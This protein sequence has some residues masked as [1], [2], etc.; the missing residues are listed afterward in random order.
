MDIIRLKK[1]NKNK[2]EII[3]KEASFVLFDD[4]ILKY[5]L[6]VNKDISLKQLNEIKKYDNFINI[7]YELIKWINRKLRSK[8]EVIVKLKEYHLSKE[9]ELLIIN[10]LESLKLINDNLLLKAYLNDQINLGLKGPKKIKYE[11]LKKGLKEDLINDEINKIDLKIWI[12]RIITIIKKKEKANHKLS[13]NNL[14]YKIINDLINLGYDKELINEVI[15]NYQFINQKD[16]LLKEYQKLKT[17]EN[18]FIEYE[19]LKK[20]F[21]K[22]EINSLKE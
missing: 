8:E 9:G 19:L 1:I 21:S 18:P 11:L 20:G 5:N 7:Y 22:E 15:N 4:T 14:K 6:L 10:K 17:K 3:T 16:I 13:I 12:D 2:Y